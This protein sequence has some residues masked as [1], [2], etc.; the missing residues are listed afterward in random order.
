[1]SVTG[2]TGCGAAVAGSESAG[3]GVADGS[4]AAGSVGP[5]VGVAV[6]PGAVGGVAGV[7]GTNT[8]LVGIGGDVAGPTVTPRSAEA[9]PTAI[10]A[11]VAAKP[12]LSTSVTLLDT[13][14]RNIVET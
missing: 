11:A 12:A 10:G 3:A 8:V 7:P 13:E 5:A 1:M 2:G 14:T 6:G 4:V 9:S